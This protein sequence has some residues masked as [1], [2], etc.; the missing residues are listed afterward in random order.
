MPG[1]TILSADEG[2]DGPIP[3]FVFATSVRVKHIS[4]SH[5]QALISTDH[6]L[7]S[8]HTPVV[9]NS[10]NWQYTSNDAANHNFIPHSC[11]MN[12][13]QA[14]NGLIVAYHFSDDMRTFWAVLFIAL[15]GDPIART[16]ETLYTS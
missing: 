15:T 2:S 9:F 14:A 10:L 3:S 8:E 16:D 4:S 6:V 7:A 12:T 1:Y 11:I 5:H 13:A